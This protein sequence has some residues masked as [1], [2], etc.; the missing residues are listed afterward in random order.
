MSDSLSPGH[1]MSLGS[2]EHPIHNASSTPEESSGLSIPDEVTFEQAIAF[3]HRLLSLVEQGNVT[4]D[5]IERVVARLVSTMNGARGFFVAYL[6][7]ERSFPEQPSSAI[8]RALCQAPD[9][10]S[11]LLVKNLAMSSAMAVAHRRRGD[12]TNAQGSEWVRSRTLTLLQHLSIPEL[13]TQLDSLQQT[14]A[15]NNGPYQAFLTRWGYDTEQR[16]AIQSAL[17]ETFA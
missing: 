16:Q 10:V 13:Q 4:S 3:T 17:A 6:T 12:E 2:N 7:D 15:S 11:E 5:I 1:P 14:L 8:V 9:I